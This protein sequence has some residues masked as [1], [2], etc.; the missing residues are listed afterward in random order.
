MRMNKYK[1]LDP[2]GFS[3]KNINCVKGFMRFTYD[4]I[5]DKIC[6]LPCCSSRLPYNN[7]NKSLKI[8]ADYFIKNFDK[9]IENYINMDLSYL[10][11]NFKGKCY[12]KEC[13]ENLDNLCYEYDGNKNI[14]EMN[15]SIAT[16]CNLNCIMCPFNHTYCK[17]E[18]ELYHIVNK[19]IT[20]Y[21]PIRW[22]PTELGEPF[23][24]KKELYEILD[25]NSF[26]EIFMFTNASLLDD[27]DINKLATY[28][29][30]KEIVISMD[31]HVKETYEKIRIG[32][33]YN[34]VI[35]N[36]MKLK[37]SGIKISVNYVAQMTNKNE[38]MDAINF[39]KE[40]DITLNLS[41]DGYL[42]KFL[43]N[44]DNIPYGLMLCN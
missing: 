28:K 38:I 30:I 20:K 15:N 1:I 44:L 13:L 36:I 9:C 27:N 19:L 32:S 4:R 22:S 37:N 26:K 3:Y 33:N 16:T 24:Y 29:N 21:N 35:N 7:Y 12:V 23:L 39:F 42:K 14:I 25:N 2:N 31:S 11:S 8:D 10:K 40:R 34:K 6:M 5:E 41:S 18:V 43:N 17:R